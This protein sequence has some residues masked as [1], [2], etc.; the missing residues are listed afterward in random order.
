MT[1]TNEDTYYSSVVSLQSMRIVIFLAELNNLDMCAGD[2]GNDFIEAY[3]DENIFSLLEKD[4]DFMGHNVHTMLISE[5]FYVLKTSGAQWHEKF[6][7]TLHQLGLS[8]SKA[9]HDVWMKY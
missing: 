3:T 1:G 9:D 5:A 7:E 6:S 4:F 8:P 2:F